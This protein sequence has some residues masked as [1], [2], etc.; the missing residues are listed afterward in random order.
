MIPNNVELTWH[1]SLIATSHSHAA[2]ASGFSH[3]VLTHTG[4]VVSNKTTETVL[5]IITTVNDTPYVLHILYAITDVNFTVPKGMA[6]VTIIYNGNIHDELSLEQDVSDLES[7]N[8]KDDD[9]LAI[10]YVWYFGSETR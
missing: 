9:T 5:S 4:F 3:H 1:S 10:C 6:C 7:N 8:S 2:N